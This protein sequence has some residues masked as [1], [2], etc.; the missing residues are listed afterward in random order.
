MLRIPLLTIKSPATLG[1]LQYER[2]PIEKKQRRFQDRYVLVP[3]VQLYEYECRAVI[4][5]IRVRLV[6]GKATQHQWI[7]QVVK[8][9]IGRKCHVCVVDETPGRVSSVFEITFQE[10]DLRQVNSICWLLDAKFDLQALPIV[11]A[12]EISVDFRSRFRD[13]HDRAKLFMA[14]TRHFEP[15][16]DVISNH[17]DWPRFTF[18]EG[19]DDTV[20]AIGRKKGWPVLDDD[21]L[22]SVDADRQPFVDACYYVGARESDIRWRIMDKVVDRQHVAAGTSVS[23]DDIDKRVRIEVTLSRSAV[24]GLGIDYLTDLA[25]LRFATLQSKFFS[26][27]LPTFSATSQLSAGAMKAVRLVHEEKREQKFLGTGA[28]GLG[29]MNTVWARRMKT[30]RKDVRSRS[31][32]SGRTMTPAKRVGR[33]ASGSF[34]AFE[35]LNERVRVALRCLGARVAAELTGA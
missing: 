26:F 20:G 16:R 6:F 35:E 33:G 7:Q 34:L 3:G 9:V 32:T 11:A 5:W 2:A 14:L 29:A 30:V 18:G 8:P 13:A 28:I 23:L 12:I 4:D 19:E 31:R 24:A 17:S 10:P 25:H 27:V 15:S 1:H 22:M 21:Y